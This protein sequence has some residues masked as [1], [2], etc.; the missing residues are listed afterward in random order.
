M[1]SNIDENVI[2]FDWLSFT[3]KKHSPEELIKALGL[4]HC[5]FTLC[6]KGVNGYKSRLYYDHISVC[7][8]GG[9]EK[10][11]GMGVNVFMSGQGCRVFESMSTLKNPWVDLFHFIFSNDLNI[12]RLDVAYDDHS[13]VL[14]IKRVCSDVYN[15]L[16]ISPFRTHEVTSS[17]RHNIEGLS[18][19]IGSMKSMLLVRIY[20]KAAERGYTD[21]RHWVRVEMQMRD[22]RA[23][24]FAHAMFE[25]DTSIGEVFAGVLLNYLRFVEPD[26]TDSNKSRWVTTDYWYEVIGDVSR[27]RLFTAPGMEYNEEACANYVFNHMGNA[28]AACMEMFGPVG[29]SQRL[30]ERSCAPNPKYLRIVE[31]HKAEESWR[32]VMALKAKFPDLVD[33]V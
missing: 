22:A 7:Y 19:V 24:A 13:G 2:L 1:E 23:N 20:D 21:G 25:E 15:H 29:F 17:Y 6:D 31:K 4:S 32:K 5:N 11:G 12:A 30:R 27:I 16:Y 8:D 26:E 33:F 3:S 10:N 9:N 28:V 18:A 14:D